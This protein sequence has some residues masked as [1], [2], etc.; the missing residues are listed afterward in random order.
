M[1]LVLPLLM[2]AI[3]GT[4]FAA[5][6]SLRA[7]VGQGLRVDP[8][9]SLQAP[10]RVGLTDSE[11]PMYFFGETVD[12]QVDDTITLVNRAEMRQLGTSLKA[13]R[14]DFDLVPNR[15]R[16]EGNVQLFREGELFTGPKLDLKLSTMQGRFEDV[17][18]EI[19]A[20]NG[21]G[22]AK[23]AEF[24]QPKATR[25]IDTLYT[26]CPK[27]RPAWT[28]Q[29]RTM[30]VDQIREVADAEGA[31][32]TWGG[33]P[34]VN[35]GDISFAIS[36]RR[37]TGL[38]PASYSYSSRL[39]L[40]LTVPFYWNI[41]PN[42]DM[43]LY[44]KLVPRRGVQLGAEFRYLSDRH[45]GVV[46]VESLPHD[47]VA[48]RSRSLG[49]LVH[50]TRLAP[51][52][53][54]GLNI[55]RVSDDDYFADFGGSLLAAS[56]RTLPATL[57]LT[58]NQYGWAVT[59]AAQEYQLLQDR[60]APVLAPYSWMPKVAASRTERAIQVGGTAGPL[61]DW[62]SYAE[63]AA[64]RHPTLAEGNR[65]VLTGAV[66]S[67]MMLS[68]LDVTPKIGLHATHYSQGSQGSASRTL[69]KYR[70]SSSSLGAYAN[71]VGDTGT[72]TESY[73]R[74][75]PTAS[76]TTKMT[77]ERDT[78]WGEASLLQTL[79]PTL[80]YTYTPYR[81]QSRYPVFDSGSVGVNL[82]QLLSG[83]SFTGHDR[84]SDQNQ[85]TAALTTRYLGQSS[86]EELF[87]ATLAQTH[88]LSAQRV[89]L[90]GG[91]LRTDKES[92]ILLES[93]ARLT[94]SWRMD[95]LGQYTRSLRRWQGAS[96]S[97]VYEPKLGQSVSLS[98]RFTRN[99]INTVDLAFQTPIVRDWYA[100]GRYN[101]SIQKRQT[102]DST[103]QPG[104]IEALA[105][106]EYD[107]GCW[108]ARAV[109]QR[110]V[111]G[112]DRRDNRIFFQVEL[113][114][115][116]KVGTDPLSALKQSIPNYRMINQLTPL[117]AKFDNFR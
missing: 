23:A 73:S 105:G 117:P 19:S 24:L 6:C 88:Y 101:H 53:S 64:F 49:S 46:G 85:V 12:G 13:D 50:T 8:R 16:A 104:L 83:M 63:A 78:S 97:T 48:G 100:V 32:L 76:L 33:V 94:K 62:S 59:A 95:V 77:L 92:D 43:T 67:P 113:N 70:V 37:R 11:T 31:V 52:L 35:M 65:F 34:L 44:P 103:Q 66:T 80:S 107:G 29:A 56:Q 4:S 1:R 55:T 9:L 39:G 71:N 57:S 26:T 72:Q 84:I 54:M 116:A 47:R 110:Y 98:Y 3:T 60:A 7:D 86:G 42:R 87:R 51:N 112:A 114:G 108:V 79:E 68:F 2:G 41:A 82:S 27:D 38:L 15:I 99:S 115:I 109:V 22:Q 61:I 14:I 30:L 20:I 28:V 10:A 75:L 111:T 40:E 5:E 17:T 81:D 18:Y 74:V 106:V 58:S 36:D 91:S 21:R 102:T 96:A 90:P 89:T 45:L 93:A 69:D 25:L